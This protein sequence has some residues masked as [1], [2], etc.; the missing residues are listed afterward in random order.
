[1]P[2]LRPDSGHLR[3]QDSGLP[4]NLTHC[5]ECGLPFPEPVTNW[6]DFFVEIEDASFACE[7]CA[8]LNGYPTAD[9]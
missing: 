7:R 8:I 9:D 5:L 2:P 3:A 1:M 6:D 4:E